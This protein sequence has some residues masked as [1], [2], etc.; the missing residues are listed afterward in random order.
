MTLLRVHDSQQDLTVKFVKMARN[1][2]QKYGMD[3]K[4]RQEV[5][6][7]GQEMGFCNDEIR[8]LL[9]DVR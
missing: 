6:L 5:F 7:Q 9:E 3:Q 8:V 2:F 1:R 4:Q